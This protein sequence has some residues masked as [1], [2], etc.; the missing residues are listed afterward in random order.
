MPLSAA[1]SS[2]R[3]RIGEMRWAGHN[4]S[5]DLDRQI[6]GRRPTVTSLRVMPTIL[7]PTLPSVWLGT[8]CILGPQLLTR[9]LCRFPAALQPALLPPTLPPIASPS[10]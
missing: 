5:G 7:L 9:A 10:T 6:R 8:L 2:I 3:L 4:H 1:S